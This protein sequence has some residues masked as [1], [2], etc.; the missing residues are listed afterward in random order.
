MTLPDRPRLSLSKRLRYALLTFFLVFLGIEVAARVGSYLMN[1]RNPYYLLYGFRSW[2]NEEGVGHT[3][4]L[5]GYFKFPE[6]V[7][8]EYGTPE[9]ARINALG[10][11]GADFTPEKPAETFRVICMG[12]SSTFGYLNADP[13]TYPV[14]LE[15]LLGDGAEVINAGIPHFTTDHILACLE[16]ELLGYQPDVLTI[17]TG[18]NDAVRPMA[19]TNIQKVQRVLD[20][21]SAGYAA[22]RKGVNATFGDVFFGQWTPYLQWMTAEGIQRQIDLHLEMTRGN[23]EK[24]IAQAKQADVPLVIVRQPITLWFE[25]ESRDIVTA[26][27]PRTAYEQEYA[28]LEQRFQEEGVLRGYEVT[29]YVHHHLNAAIDELAREHGLTVV[30]NVALLAE[31][32]DGLG[33]KVHLTASANERLAQALFEAIGP[34]RQAE[35][36]GGRE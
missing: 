4:K 10:F 20:E 36:G 21:Y 35:G 22:L 15:G 30:D 9:P 28:E 3:V 5:D 18:C 27:S 2:S 6:N 13:D 7:V 17:Y 33:S 8:I 14:R 29:L 12:A 1:G 19:E 24:I 25:R 26:D 32:P 11:R 34:L 16:Q 23:F 31:E